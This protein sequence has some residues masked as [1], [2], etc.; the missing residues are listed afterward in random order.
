MGTA[1]KISNNVSEDALDKTPSIRRQIL[2]GYFILTVVLIF[3]M[4]I[5]IISLQLTG[6]GYN[7]INRYLTQQEKAQ[8]V[9]TAHYQWLEHLSES[10]STGI[11]FTGS[12]DPTNCA[13]GK[14]LSESESEINSDPIM[15][16]NLDEIVAPH[17]EIHLTASELIDMSK[18][19]KEEALRM[20]SSKY[21]PNVELI[22]QGLSEVSHRY[23]EIA[24]ELDAKNRQLVSLCNVILF[25]TGIGAICVSIIV[26]QKIAK[27]IAVPIEAV[28]N[29]SEELASGVDNFH[30]DASVLT[31]KGNSR[32][33]NKMISSFEKMASGIRENVSVI[34]RV[35]DGDLTAYVDIKSKGDSLGKNLYH[36]VQ[37]NDI[38]F[39]NL[40]KVADSVASNAESI[41]EASQSLANSSTAQSAAVEVLSETI[42]Q[43]DE[44][45]AKNAQKANNAS[46]VISDMQ[47]EVHIG[48]ERMDTLLESV[49]EIKVASE[50]ISGVMKSINDIAFQ[51]NILALNAAVEAARAG[52]AGKGFAVVA[53]EVRNLSIKSAEAAEQSRILIENTI[54][55]TTE[56]SKISH[57][58]SD[59]FADIVERTGDIYNIMSEINSA[60]ITQ[61][62]YIAEVH[63]E[64]AKITAVVVS[65]AAASEQTAA[66]TK[67]MHGNAAIIKDFMKKFNLRKRQEGKPYIPPEKADDPEFIQEAERNYMLKMG[68]SISHRKNI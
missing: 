37:N 44:L 54:A 28:E 39:A 58:A 31:N 19:A 13:L 47:K 64:I 29:W 4:I 2:T 34:Q 23:Q 10:I 50:K 65:N 62:N 45:A 22:G 7:K 27:R 36:L 14:W 6:R 60:S 21:K 67:E 40:L 25:L 63:E 17:R 15:K 16:K 66:A 26:G 38:M 51:T 18:T 55:K 57:E 30:F 9:I 56:G 46:L 35:A 43:A 5:S 3:L 8:E 49:D 59:T 53:D 48:K 68:K 1:K 52:E 33:I 32:E 20:Y 42:G 61:Q 12:L 24:S 11:P 41:A